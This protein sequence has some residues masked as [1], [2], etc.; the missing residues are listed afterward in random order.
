M[1]SRAAETTVSDL[2]GE[3]RQKEDGTDLVYGAGLEY[4]FKFGLA[5]RAEWEVFANVSD[6]DIDL[7]SA[8]VSYTF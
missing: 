6:D 8:G 2:N 5:L 4:R 7:V 1:D 3:L